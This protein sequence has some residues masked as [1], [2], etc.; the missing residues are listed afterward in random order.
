[1]DPDVDD[2]GGVYEEHLLDAMWGGGPAPSACRAS[3][4]PSAAASPV[5]L[6]WAGWL[7]I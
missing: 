3:V 6:V 4:R 2:P 5:G 1:M 7:V